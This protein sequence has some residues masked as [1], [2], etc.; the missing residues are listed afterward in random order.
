MKQKYD[1]VI[2][3]GTTIKEK[4]R[5]QMLKENCNT[6]ENL[7]KCCV[8]NNVKKFILTSSGMVYGN[9]EYLPIDEIHPKKTKTNYGY[10][11]IINEEKCKTYSKKYGI[12]IVILRVSSVYGPGQNEKFVIPTLI[13]NAVKNK[14]ITLH[15]YQNGFQLMDYV[16]V[17]DVCNAVIASCRSKV[18]CGIYN[19]A[20][21]K[22]ITVLDIGQILKKIL[23]IRRIIVKEMKS[24]TEHYFYDISLAKK[25][26]KFQPKKKIDRKTMAKIIQY[27]NYKP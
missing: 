7:L 23:K 16:H 3:L 22:P 18:K 17:D 11:K 21:G 5:I 13:K 25:K 2:H 20:S 24:N 8:E 27:Y 10:S 6:T 26:L 4:N 12:E 14:V 1:V 19:I 15:R 9:T